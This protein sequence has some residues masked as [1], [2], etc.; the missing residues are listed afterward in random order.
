MPFFI[1]LAKYTSEGFKHV[2]ELPKIGKAIREQIEKA[3]GKWHGF[4]LT[5]G[6][7]DFVLTVELPSDETA[8]SLLLGGLS[9]GYLETVTLKGVPQAVAD[10]VI[11]GLPAR[12]T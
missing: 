3:G 7:Y 12:P 9:L 5:F 4:Y 11:E 8:L 1:I 6:P 2:K 10:K